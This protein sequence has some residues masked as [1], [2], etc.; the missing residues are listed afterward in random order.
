MLWRT[1]K[2]KNQ[3]N[4]HNRFGLK[5]KCTRDYKIILVRQRWSRKYVFFRRIWCDWHCTTTV[6]LFADPL[7]L[8][9][10]VQLEDALNQTRPSVGNNYFAFFLKTTFTFHKLDLLL[11]QMSIRN[12]PCPSFLLFLSKNW[13]QLHPWLKM[14]ARANFSNNNKKS[15][16]CW[17]DQLFVISKR[18]DFVELARNRRIFSRRDILLHKWGT[19]VFEMLTFGLLNIK[20]HLSS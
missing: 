16:C 2:R 4:A 13:A 12:R 8:E 9:L 15:L 20:N 11:S 19:N 14:R 6:F 7:K 10:G 1:S 3:Q 17:M 5:M 18:P